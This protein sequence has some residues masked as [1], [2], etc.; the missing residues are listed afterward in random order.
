MDV[1]QLLLL[2]FLVL[3]HRAMGDDI[4][5]EVVGAEGRSVTFLIH[6]LDGEAAAWSFDDVAIVTVIFRDPPGVV[7]LDKKYKTRFTFSEQGRALTISQL[8][9]EDA[10]TYSLQNSEG[11]STF[12][13]QVY[14]ELAEPRVSCEAQNCSGGGCR[15]ALR[16][17]APGPG[18]GSVSYGWS[19]G[20][21]PRGEGPTVLLEESPPHGSVSL[22][23]RA[24]NPVS[25][26]SV[27][28]WPGHLCAASASAP[29]PAI[30]AC[31]LA[32]TGVVVLLVA[33]FYCRSRGWRMFPLSAAE[34]TDTGPRQ[35]LTTVYA[36][37]NPWQ[38]NVPNATRDN[39]RGENSTTIYA[40]VKAPAQTDDEKMGSTVLGGQEVE[41]KSIYSLVV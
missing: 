40:T 18:L 3:L 27:T 8:R 4:V 38:Q 23:C 11:K 15:Y 20:E 9:M 1:P 16:C 26:S 34:A 25:N 14:R 30:V 28:V 7:F 31:A 35:E 13:L 33:V 19:E 39:P 21:Q 32:V 29:L 22:T 12:T 2:T 36:Q 24:R 5:T 41:E 17:S 37:V 10:G 6:H